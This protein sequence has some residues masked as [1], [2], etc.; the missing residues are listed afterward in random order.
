[1]P[2]FKDMVQITNDNIEQM[3][4]EAKRDRERQLNL[5]L[6]D[7]EEEEYANVPWR[8]MQSEYRQSEH[9]QTTIPEGWEYRP[10]ENKPSVLKVIWHHVVEL[11]SPK[12]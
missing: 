4:A 1:M 10:P 2:W 3:V 12:Q 11:V 6:W 9:K 7:S 8:Y 5:D